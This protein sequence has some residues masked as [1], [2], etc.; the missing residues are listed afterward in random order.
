MHTL[1]YWLH[2]IFWNQFIYC[3]KLWTDCESTLRRVNNQGAVFGAALKVQLCV[4]WYVFHTMMLISQLRNLCQ[5][6]FLL[7]QEK[8]DNVSLNSFSFRISSNVSTEA[9]N[10]CSSRWRQFLLTLMRHLS[11]FVVSK[12]WHVWRQ[13]CICCCIVLKKADEKWL[14]I[15][16]LIGSI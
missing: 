2:F 3:E 7:T 6:C 14:W 10:N 16:L 4:V 1:T 8:L 15:P 5:V 11:L 12:L 9:K 13:L